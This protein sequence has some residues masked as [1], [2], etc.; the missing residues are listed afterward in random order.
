MTYRRLYVSAN[1][2]AITVAIVAGYKQD[3]ILV[4]VALMLSLSLARMPP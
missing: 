2:L 1:I 3:L 4:A